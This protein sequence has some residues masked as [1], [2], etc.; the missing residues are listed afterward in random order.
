MSNRG[1]RT[2]SVPDS[3]W[4]L[5]LFKNVFARTIKVSNCV[6]KHVA[7]I[8]DGN[9]RYARKKDIEIKEGHE[10][11]F[12]SMGKI[13][14]LCYESG[15]ET[16][17]VFAFSIENFKRSSKE[18]EQLMSLARERIR[19]ITENGD[20]AQRFG[21]RVRVIGDL[22]LLPTEV[23]KEVETATEITKYNTRA[24]LNICF[25][26][27]GREEIF[28]S[29]KNVVKQNLEI[30]SINELTLDSNVYTSGL[31][32]L[33]LLVR[34]SGVSR[35]SDFMLWQSCNKGVVIELIDCLWP[36]FTPLYMAWVLLKFVFK[37]SFL[38]NSYKLN[39]ETYDGE[40]FNDDN[41]DGNDQDEEY[42][43]NDDDG[44]ERLNGN[45][46]TN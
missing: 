43:G 16:T 20:I 30:D 5:R 25:P 41:D 44:N 23:L 9:R 6:P 18:V 4:S 37:K 8:M 27:T 15:V 11:G 21:I 22:S 12:I 34:T 33:D 19:Q 36:D 40:I 26:Y 38:N 31:P 3:S 17:T 10:A 45:K 32:P 2:S 39:E 35:L 24:T 1:S 28:H 46:K 7:F 42:D 29:I 14:E 13:L